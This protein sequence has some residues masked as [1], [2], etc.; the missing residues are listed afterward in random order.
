M[1]NNYVRLTEVESKLKGELT[2][3]LG[4]INEK[5][6]LLKKTGVSVS[7]SQKAFNDGLED[8]YVGIDLRIS[9]SV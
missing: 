2:E 5:I 6:F 4:E 9:V 3:L 7:I 8:Y 1:T